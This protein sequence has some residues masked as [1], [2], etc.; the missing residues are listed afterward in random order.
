[1]KLGGI[2]FVFFLQ[3]LPLRKSKKVSDK[4]NGSL[5]RAWVNSNN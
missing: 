5:G 4:I 1:M 2:W 3:Y